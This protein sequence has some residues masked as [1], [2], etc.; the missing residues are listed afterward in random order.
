[1]QR[2]KS[3]FRRSR[4]PNAVSEQELSTMHEIRHAPLSSESPTEEFLTSRSAA[5]NGTELLDAN[6]EENMREINLDSTAEGERV[7]IAS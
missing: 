5:N 2:L 4:P 1:M 3:L 7:C 6:D